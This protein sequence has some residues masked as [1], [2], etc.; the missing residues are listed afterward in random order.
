MIWQ[1]KTEA[2]REII[3]SK[4]DVITSTRKQDVHSEEKGTTMLGPSTV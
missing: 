2:E 4:I 3:A 1:R